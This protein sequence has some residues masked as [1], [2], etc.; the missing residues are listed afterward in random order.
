MIGTLDP[1]NGEEEWSYEKAFDGDFLTRFSSVLPS[2]AW[3]GIDFGKPVNIERFRCIPRSDDN[4]IRT[5]DEYEL[6]YWNEIDWRSL[7][8]KTGETDVL[9]FDDV[10][11]KALLLLRNHTR[12]KEERP[13]TYENGKQLWW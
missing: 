3:I 6:L 10:P 9:H 13:F 8:R 2:Y 11:E 12:G 1:Y 7:G 4:S 5:G